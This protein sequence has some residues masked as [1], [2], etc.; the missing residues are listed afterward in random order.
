MVCPP[1]ARPLSIAVLKCLSGPDPHSASVEGG[2]VG[3]AP[4]AQAGVKALGRG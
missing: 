4:A 2:L 1:Y 3:S